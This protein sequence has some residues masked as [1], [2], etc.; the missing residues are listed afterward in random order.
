MKKLLISLLVIAVAAVAAMLV[1][2][3]ISEG[4]SKDVDAALN[5]YYDATG[6]TFKFNFGEWGK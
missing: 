3:Y 5:G 4:A 1:V 2:S 6:T